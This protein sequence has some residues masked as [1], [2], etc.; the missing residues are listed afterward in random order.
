MRKVI[1]V[2]VISILIISSK[3]IYAQQSDKVKYKKEVNDPDKYANLLVGVNLNVLVQND[4]TSGF[5][6]MFDYHLSPKTWIGANINVINYVKT[7][8]DYPKSMS[9]QE[10]YGFYDFKSKTGTTKRGIELKRD[11]T[12]M[13]STSMS[14]DAEAIRTLSLHYG[15][16]INTNAIR[17]TNMN[18][19]KLIY[20]YDIALNKLIASKDGAPTKYVEKLREQKTESILALGLAK[21][22]ITNIE[23]STDK[24]GNRVDSR[25]SILY[26]DVLM[27]FGGSKSQIDSVY[28]PP[29]IPASSYKEYNT[30]KKIGWRVG[31]QWNAALTKKIFTKISIEAGVRPNTLKGFYFVY[32]QTLPLIPI[33][34]IPQI[35][36]L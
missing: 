10:L 29:Q 28:T 35:S 6:F 1:L 24:Y 16:I 7:I 33:R 11:Y 4:V 12:T 36:F 27:G 22:V 15:L 14:V 19:Q 8:N 21:Q 34:K 32:G 25:R 30:I 9:H 31:W 17:N 26:A 13:T 18:W 23:V 20:T 3:D 2:A 5:G